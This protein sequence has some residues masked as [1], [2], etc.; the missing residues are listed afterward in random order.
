M[1]DAGWI[2][3][4][5]CKKITATSTS[6]SSTPVRTITGY[7]TGTYRTTA[8]LHVR[9]G[10]STKYRAKTYRELTANAR[11]QNRQLGNYYYNG[12][13]SGATVTVSKVIKSGSYYWGKIPSGY[14]CLNY[15]KKIN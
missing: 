3:L 2:C 10:A 5:Y 1:N 14:I 11:K 7:R 6:Q 13:K 9:T 12:L 8:N 15:C 4:D